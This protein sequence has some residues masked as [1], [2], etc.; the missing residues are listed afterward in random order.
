MAGNCMVETVAYFVFR[1]AVIAR[2]RDQINNSV[3]AL[4]IGTIL[5]GCFELAN[6][7]KDLIN[8]FWAFHP[9]LTRSLG[10]F[11]CILMLVPKSSFTDNI[12]HIIILQ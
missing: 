10:R 8:C 2:F 12:I 9:L 6:N 11:H 4:M 7:L 5:V 3:I 1:Q